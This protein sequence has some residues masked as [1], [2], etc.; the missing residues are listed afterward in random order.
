M[1]STQNVRFQ[2]RRDT[3]ANWNST[4]IVLLLGEPGY[5]TQLNVLKIG[6]GSSPWAALPAVSQGPPGRNGVNGAPGTNGVNGTNGA[7]GRDGVDGNDGADGADGVDGVDG[8]DG[9]AAPAI[10]FD[11]GSSAVPAYAFGPVFDC[12]SSS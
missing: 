5:D 9:A 1:S 8:N 4:P 3:T 11:G 6:N 10:S 7:P 12:G 2:L